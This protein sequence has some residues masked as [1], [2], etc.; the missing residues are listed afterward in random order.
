MSDSDSIPL[1]D[2]SLLS[3]NLVAIAGLTIITLGM[4]SIGYASRLALVPAA[5]SSPIRAA[6]ALAC[7]ATSVGTCIAQ[8]D[9]FFGDVGLDQL[10]ESPLMMAFAAFG[11]LTALTAGYILPASA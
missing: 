4:V 11:C 9:N 8:S 7:G 3:D 5:S 1:N 10:K 6:V 2:L